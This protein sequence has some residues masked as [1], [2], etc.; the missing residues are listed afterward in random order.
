VKVA[1]FQRT[2]VSHFMREADQDPPRTVENDTAT[3][4]LVLDPH[5]PMATAR[6]LLADRFTYKGTRILHHH[7]AGFYLWMKTKYVELDALEIRTRVYAFCE[8]ARVRNSK[9]ALESFRPSTRKI[10]DIIDALRAAAHLPYDIEPPAWL[11]E[12]VDLPPNELIP[13]VNGL[14]YLPD[15]RLLPHDPTYFGTSALPVAY[16]P[17][18]P[19][20]TTWLSFLESLWR[21]DPESVACL[22]EVFG[23]NLTMDTR[24]QKIVAIAGPRRSG[25]G[26]IARVETGLLGPENVVAPTL[27]SL[28]QRFGLAPL[29]SKPLAIIADARLSSRSDPAGVLEALLNISGEDTVTIDRKHREPW[30]GKLPTRVW[31]LSNELPRLNDSSRSL[32]GRFILLILRHSFYGKEDTELTEKLLA[33]RAGMLNWSLDGLARLN[34]RGYFAMPSSSEEA[35]RQ[36]EDL[37]SPV[38]AFVRDRCTVGPEHEV[39]VDGLYTAWRSW[40]S[41]Q[42]RDRPGIKATFGRDLRAAVPGI[43]TKARRPDNRY[44]GIGLA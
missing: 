3:V 17:D 30:T 5:D 11:D 38:G 2:A 28:G 18:A 16:D 15:R 33:E 40:C 27:L 13:C 10:S 31:L 21:D 22:Q 44:V 20:P 24:Q 37:S 39:L 26:T 34:E 8:P 36:L 25:K 43:T 19:E 29:I 12:A 4:P 14:L 41:E 23:H 6:R 7:R 1:A 42:G 35:I 9:G 32:A